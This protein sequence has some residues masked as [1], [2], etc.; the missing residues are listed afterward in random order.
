MQE[1]DFSEADQAFENV[2]SEA[3]IESIIFGPDIDRGFV[4]NSVEHETA[5]AFS[6]L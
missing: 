5:P 2:A 4:Q 1:F 3:G 6:K